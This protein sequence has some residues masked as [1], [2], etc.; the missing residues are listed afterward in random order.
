MGGYIAADSVI[1]DA[2]RS[3]APGFI[4]TTSLAPALAAGARASVE[5]L[6]S[7]HHLREQHQ[8]RA[9]TLKARFAEA[10]LPVMSS[11]THIVPLKVGDPVLC[12]RMTDDLLETHGIYVQPINYPTVPRGT[13][14]MRFTPTPL[15]TDEMIDE[16]VHA[17]QAVYAR[18]AAAR[19]A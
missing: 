17:L 5:F 15:H 7:A 2:V 9:A 14:R 6:K 12:K 4:F 19:T 8:E 3:W 1:I 10:G 13:E 16:L 18:H 11:D